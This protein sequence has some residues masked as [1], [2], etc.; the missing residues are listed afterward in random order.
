MDVLFFSALGAAAVSAALFSYYLKQR[1]R[2]EL[3]TVAWQLGLEFSPQDVRGC[4]G[5]PFA[6]LQK[7][8]GWEAENVMW[9]VW[10]EISV[11]EFDYWYDEESGDP[12]GYHRKN[13]H[14]FSC[15]VAEIDAACSPIAIDRESLTTRILDAIGLDDIQFEFEEFNGAF[16]MSSRD[17][18]FANDLIDQRMM[19]WLL[20]SGKE[21]RF[22]ACG[23][24]LL[25][26]GKRRRPRAL[27]PLLGAL[28]QFRDRVPRVV[29]DLYPRRAVG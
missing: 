15:V 23:P 14:R 16:N 22:E 26:F 9:G 19:G 29:F 8:D 18:R 21:F 3:A 13:Y 20:E 27:I 17:R 28:K 12:K 4:L 5:L 11:H 6:L 24:W 7:G 2:E 10:Q 25:C 1:R